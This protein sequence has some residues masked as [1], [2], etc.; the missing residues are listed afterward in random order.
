METTVIC[1]HEN[2]IKFFG[3]TLDNYPVILMEL[4]DISLRVAY[5]Q[6]RITDNQKPQI[7]CNVAQALHYLHNLPVGPVIHRDVSSANVLLKATDIPNGK[8]LVKLG[9]LGTATIQKHAAT[10]GPGAIPYAAPEVA[11]PYCHSPK[12]DVYS[13]GILVLEVLTVT[14]PYL[15]IN[16][17]KLRVKR[18]FP[19]YYEV[20]KRA[21]R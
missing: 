14:H 17:L 4:M 11:K 12:M 8:W 18:Q 9:D 20:Y 13:F 19:C 10:P 6:N 2:I 21:V 1:Q 15:K 3:A 7:L 16:D 5:G